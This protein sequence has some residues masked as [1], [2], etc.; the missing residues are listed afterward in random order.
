MLLHANSIAAAR[1]TGP[2]GSDGAGRSG[3]RCAPKASDATGRLA[4]RGSVALR[5]HRT[6]LMRR[7]FV[8]TEQRG[9]VLGVYRIN[10]RA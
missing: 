4:P 5:L 6:R 8:I 1:V 3:G 7:L 10:D 9:R 2:V